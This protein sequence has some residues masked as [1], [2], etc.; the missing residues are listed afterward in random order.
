MRDSKGR[1]E[2]LK[3]VGA[4]GG[5]I[6]NR[7]EMVITFKT[8]NGSTHSKVFQDAAVGMPIM[9]A[10]EMTEEDL[11]VI[12]RKKGGIVRHPDGQEFKIIKRSGVFFIEMR[13]PKHLACPK[14]SS[15]QDFHRPGNA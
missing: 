9:S 6:P 3:Y 8:E 2:G 1:K 11:E 4:T 12:L 15:N 10:G 14:E 5:E 7:G 13:V